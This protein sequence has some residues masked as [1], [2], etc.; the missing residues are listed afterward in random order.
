MIHICDLNTIKT[1]CLNFLDIYHINKGAY[2]QYFI[3][4]IHVSKLSLEIWAT[5][6]YGEAEI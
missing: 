5:D 3:G 1:K 4:G 6:T 2:S